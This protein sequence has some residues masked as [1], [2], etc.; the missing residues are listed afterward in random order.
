MISPMDDVERIHAGKPYN[1]L[2][3]AFVNKIYKEIKAKNAT[4]RPIVKAIHFSDVHVDRNYKIG[5][6][7]EC[8]GAYT[9]CCRNE[10]GFPSDPSKKAQ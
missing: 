7:I 1:V 3:D 10:H 2:D 9:S 6:N 4:T 5:A 8:P